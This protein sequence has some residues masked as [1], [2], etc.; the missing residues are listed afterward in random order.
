MLSCEQRRAGHTRRATDGWEATECG[1]RSK[2]GHVLINQIQV[3]AT[4]TTQPFLLFTPLHITL[5]DRW[6]RQDTDSLRKY[7][8]VGSA[9]DSRSKAKLCYAAPLVI[10]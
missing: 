10:S 6:R 7:G 3:E 8:V 5:P 2:T 9:N 1:E 4:T